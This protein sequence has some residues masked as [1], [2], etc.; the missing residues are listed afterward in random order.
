VIGDV[1]VGQNPKVNNLVRG[2]QEAHYDWILI[3]D[4]NVRVRHDYLTHVVRGFT[5]DVGVVTAIVAGRAP[6]SQGAWLEAVFLNTFYARWMMIAGRFGAPVVVGKSM[7]FRRREA[8]RFGGIATL[9]CFLAEDY[10]AG[11]AMRFLGRRVVV[12]TEPVSQPLGEYPLASFWSRHLRWGRIRKAQAPVAFIFEPAFCSMFSG[13]IGALALHLVWNTPVLPVL[14]LHLL[15]WLCADLAVMRALGER[16]C[17]RA[18]AAW[19]ARELLHIP[20]WVHI[21]LGREVQWRGRSL[22][23]ARGGILEG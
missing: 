8:N 4:S 6:A 9:G 15:L 10:M 12:M 5:P 21:F 18:V 2:Y 3:S 7:L 13:L 1:Q 16:P 22:I 11:Q 14:G 19:L 23:V 20:L 17:A